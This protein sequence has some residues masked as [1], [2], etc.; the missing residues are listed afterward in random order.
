LI[1]DPRAG[2]EADEVSCA[3]AASLDQ[4]SE[5]P[6]AEA[7]VRQLASEGCQL[8]KPQNFESGSGIGV[9]AGRGAPLALG[10]TA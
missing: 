10:N 9:A 2:P 1:A 5:H 4:G 6:L 7:I 3:Q 8:E